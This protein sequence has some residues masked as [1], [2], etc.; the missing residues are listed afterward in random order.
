MT[1]FTPAMEAALQARFATVF[2]AVK[3][4]LPDATIC[5]VDGGIVTFGGDTYVSKNDTFGALA[6]VD[7]IRDGVG[8]EAP[9]LSITLLPAGDAEAAALSSPTYQGSPVT[10]Y[11]GAVDPET[12]A[13]IA[14]P[15]EVFYGELD[16]PTLTVDQ[17]V[18]EL[19][20]QSTSAHERFFSGD[21]GIRLSDSHHQSIWPG[22]TGL[23]NVTGIQRTIY[24]GIDKPAGSVTYSGGGF[25]GGSDS[26]YGG[27]LTSQGYSQL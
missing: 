25:S 26:I 4:E 21:E 17:G 12:G 1:L 18:R 10:L 11:L 16:Q 2:G 14:D 15:L 27:G 19:E 24:W 22:E 7:R 23:A 9:A 6:A 20:Y 13:V 5:L 3:I 8:D